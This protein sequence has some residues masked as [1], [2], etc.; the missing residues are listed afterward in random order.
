MER[1]AAVAAFREQRAPGA[2]EVLNGLNNGI[3]H[4]D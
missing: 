1:I 2:V 4:R 3:A